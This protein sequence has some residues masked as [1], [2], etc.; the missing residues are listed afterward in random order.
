MYLISYFLEENLLIFKT[1]IFMTFNFI[2]I[3][4]SPEK[5]FQASISTGTANGGLAAC[6]PQ[7]LTQ[8]VV[9]WP[10]LKR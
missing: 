2:S 3:R 7:L 1:Q 6:E 9:E 5:A 8:S 10:E 4:E